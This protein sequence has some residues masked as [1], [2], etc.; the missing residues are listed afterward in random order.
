MDKRDEFLK[1][2][3]GE[4]IGTITDQSSSDELFQNQVL[5]PILKLQNDLFIASF[6][7][8]LGK[9]RIDFDSFSVE[10]KLA[11][12]ENAIQKDI[13]FRNALKGIIIALFTLDEYAQY[14]KNSSS[15]NK[16]MMGMLIERLKSQVQLFELNTN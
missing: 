12:I 13:K 2:F 6:I 14:I 15:L 9:N 10:K 1:E 5:R 3:R 4:T 16:R 8:H 11:T 7:N